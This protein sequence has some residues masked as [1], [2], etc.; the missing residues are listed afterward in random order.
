MNTFK[1]LWDLD[2]IFVGQEPDR[3]AVLSEN[4]VK[5]QGEAEP[6]PE[7][8]IVAA[9]LPADIVHVRFLILPV[10]RKKELEELLPFQAEPLFPYPQE[11]GVLTYQILEKRD[12]ETELVLFGAHVDP[13]A[14]FLQKHPS[15]DH[16]FAPQIALTAFGAK[17]VHT[18]R[19]Y[20]LFHL[21]GSIL[22]AL[23]LHK[24]RL[25]G[26][27]TEQI[28]EKNP[29]RLEVALHKMGLALART[30]PLKE[31][32]GSVL[33]GDLAD[34]TLQIPVEELPIEKAEW[35]RAALAMGLAELANHFLPGLDFL[36]KQFAPPRP[37][38]RVLFPLLRYWGGIA[39]F[40]LAF[41][42]FILAF[43]SAKT[44]S[45]R[46]DYLQLLSD[47]GRAPEQIEKSLQPQ[48]QEQVSWKE[49][50]Q[51]EIET[52]LLFLS[53]ELEKAPQS[54]PL[55]PNIPTVSDFLAWLS[56]HPAIVAQE[57]GEKLQ[58]E[59]LSYFLVKRPTDAKKLDPYQ[60]K[61]EIDFTSPLPK[62][63]RAF[64][65]ALI[66][67]NPWVDPRAEIK[68]NASHGRYQTS[69]FLKISPLN[70]S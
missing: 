61:V 46:R 7:K 53:E 51:E 54:F 10:T 22:T 48:G 59:H 62:W 43:S 42:L 40:S 50:S 17:Y 28:Q 41:Y 29:E 13:I 11:G 66:T 14:A 31:L 15:L 1:K 4:E 20:L 34:L 68:W 44:D 12:N 49:L 25:K 3:V 57:E 5:I 58:I 38:K 16:L 67:P 39:F 65:D 63:A 69:F 60:I 26:A 21:Q 2:L 27:F 64:H 18:E 37:W 23:L 47:L 32:E 35:K 45:L 36:Q 24:K 33:T 52:R 9:A 55:F 70:R 6:W 56:T 30:T 19:P 8:A